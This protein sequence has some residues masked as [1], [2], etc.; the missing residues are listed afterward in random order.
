[1]WRRARGR[2]NQLDAILDQWEE[3][4][5]GG[6]QVAPRQ[7][8]AAPGGAT[9]GTAPGRQLD[10]RE[11]PSR[12]PGSAFPRGVPAVQMPVQEDVARPINRPDRSNGEDR[13]RGRPGDP[14][15]PRPAPGPVGK[16]F[17]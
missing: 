2:R 17:W 15:E 5:S 4:E 9:G 3:A 16:E 13:A 11:R 6:G 10:A 12:A 1:M 8:Q 7:D 14:G